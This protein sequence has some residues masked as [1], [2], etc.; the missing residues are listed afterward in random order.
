M[1]TTVEIKQTVTEYFKDKPVKKDYLF[2][3]F[4][5]RKNKREISGNTMET[6]NN[7]S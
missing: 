2:C 4:N 1:L 3:K 7:H 6:N 5:I